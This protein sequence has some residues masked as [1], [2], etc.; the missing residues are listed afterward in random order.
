MRR[1]WRGGAADQADRLEVLAKL[2]AA[3]PPAKS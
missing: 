1:R 2:L 3:T